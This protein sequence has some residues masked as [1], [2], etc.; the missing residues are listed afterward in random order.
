MKKKCAWWIVINKE[1]KILLTKKILN[2][3]KDSEMALKELQEKRNYDIIQIMKQWNCSFTKWKIKKKQ[4]PIEAAIE[5][6]E[7]EGWINRNQLK[8]IWEL[9]TFI[10]EKKYWTKETRMFLFKV[11][12]EIELNPTDKKHISGRFNINRALQI[13]KPNEHKFLLE[14]ISNIERESI[15]T[16]KIWKTKHIINTIIDKFNKFVNQTNDKP[17]TNTWKAK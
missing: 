17:K 4:T 16:T 5:E 7:E 9:G 2:S 3:K 6:I 8:L 13:I 15:K 11:L 1:W 10:K 12:N 14:N